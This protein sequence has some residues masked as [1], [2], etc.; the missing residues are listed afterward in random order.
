MKDFARIYYV[1]N[2]WKAD[3][4]AKTYTFEEDM[5]LVDVQGVF[6][7]KN[8]PTVRETDKDKD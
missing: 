2:R 3:Y 6:S 5:P 1:G 8:I 4:L 7:E